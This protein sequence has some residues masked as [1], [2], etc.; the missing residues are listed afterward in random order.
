MIFSRTQTRR[1]PLKFTP[2]SPLTTTVTL[3]KFVFHSQLEFKWETFK[4]R[5]YKHTL[6]QDG[7]P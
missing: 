1:D 2:T 5:V 7:A 3:L 6:L 4:L